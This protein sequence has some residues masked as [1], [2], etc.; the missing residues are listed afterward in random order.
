[1]IKRALDAGVHGILVP[2]LKIKKDAKKNVPLLEVDK[3]VEQHPHSGPFKQI[4]TTDYPQQV[5]DSLVTA[6]VIETKGGLERVKEIAAVPGIDV[7]FIGTFDL[8]VSIGHPILGPLKPD[9]DLIDA[10]QSIQAG[11]DAA[12]KASGIYCDTGEQAREYAHQDFHR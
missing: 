5:N 6:V 2:V 4:G 11:V 1:M 10:V 8:G 7:F 3:F 12:G 9:Q